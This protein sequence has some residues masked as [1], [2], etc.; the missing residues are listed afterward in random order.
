M[1]R[2]QLAQQEQPS[3]LAAG[4]QCVKV[5]YANRLGRGGASEFPPTPLDAV[6]LC[7]KMADALD[8]HV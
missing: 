7:R 8:G 6:H 5:L 1:A 2:Q 3:V 4:E